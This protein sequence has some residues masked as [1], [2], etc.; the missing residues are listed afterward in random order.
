MEATDLLA[1]T[2]GAREGEIAALEW[3]QIDSKI[4]T[5]R[6]EQSLSVEFGLNLKVT[7]KTDRDRMV[8]IP[9]ALSDLLDQYHKQK[10]KDKNI[11][12]YD[13]GNGIEHLFIFSNLQEKPIRPDSISQWWRR[14]TNKK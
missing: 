5:I 11:I 12:P 3:K 1:F 2:V 8:K 7:T 13:F 4:H 14:F 9:T 10:I 6:I